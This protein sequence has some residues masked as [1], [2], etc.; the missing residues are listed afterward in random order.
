MTMDFVRIKNESKD[1]I[2]GHVMMLFLYLIG[3]YF[4][5]FISMVSFF[6]I[7]FVPILS[8]SLYYLILQ[9]KTKQTLGTALS[10]S[11]LS[12]TDVKLKIIGVSFIRFLFVF[13]GTLLL[14]IPGIIMFY[15]YRMATFIMAE[16]KDIDIMDALYKSKQM[17]K[18]FR[19][20]F[21][22]FQISFILHWLLGLISGG[23]YFIYFIPYY[24][25]AIYSYF[26]EL[27]KRSLNVT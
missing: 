13:L 25:T 16:E 11:A 22:I 24:Q 1:I 14:I 23:F 3:F 27:K 8:I 17:M 5:I 26:W 15:N 19:F 7:I 2:R 10:K 21:F 9:L 18:G 6:G 20:N 12:Q 4:L